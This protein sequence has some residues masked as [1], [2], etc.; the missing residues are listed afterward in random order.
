MSFWG[1]ASVLRP[2]ITSLRMQ[3]RAF[4]FPDSGSL[5]AFSLTYKHNKY[6]VYLF[7]HINDTI[8]PPHP[9]KSLSCQR[10]LSKMGDHAY[11]QVTLARKGLDRHMTT[12]PEQESTNNSEGAMNFPW[13]RIGVLQVLGNPRAKAYLRWF[14]GLSKTRRVSYLQRI[15][16][17]SPHRTKQSYK[18]QE[19]TGLWT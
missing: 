7:I 3:N 12:T 17:T 2:C 13:G 5:A 4:F 10:E 1:L 8:P 15:V 11:G 16:G 14:Q 19:V 18:R 6:Y 9:R